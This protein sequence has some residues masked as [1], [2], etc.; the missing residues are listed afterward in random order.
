MQIEGAVEGYTP[1][2]EE[3]EEDDD[4]ATELRVVPGDPDS[5]TYTCNIR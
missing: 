1:T 4:T 3:D 2:E 5:C